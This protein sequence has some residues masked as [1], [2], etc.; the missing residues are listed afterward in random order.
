MRQGNIIG[1]MKKMGWRFIFQDISNARMIIR[2]YLVWPWKNSTAN[3]DREI[4]EH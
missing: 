4:A 1:G 3:G 2:L